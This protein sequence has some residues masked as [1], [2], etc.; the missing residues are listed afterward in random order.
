MYIQKTTLC[1]KRIKQNK[2]YKKEKSK[3]TKKLNYEGES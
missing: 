2:E 3:N 1:R